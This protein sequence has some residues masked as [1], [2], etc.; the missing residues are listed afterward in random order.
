MH[1]LITDSCNLKCPYCFAGDLIANSA[2]KH[3]SLEDFTT[4][5]DFLEGSGHRFLSLAG[6]EPSL[7]PQASDFITL[8]AQRG[9]H[10]IFLITNGL[11]QPGFSAFL[12]RNIQQVRFLWNLNSRDQYQDHHWALLNGNLGTLVLEGNSI[13]G[14]NIFQVDQDFNSFLDLCREYRPARVRCGFAHQPASG[15]AVRTI[16]PDSLSAITH[17]IA[18]LIQ[19]LAEELRIP[20][21]LDCGFVPCVW[22]ERDLGRILLFTDKRVGCTLPLA[23]DPD[24][25]V[26]CCWDFK[27]EHLGNFGTVQDIRRFFST[28]RE[29]ERAALP[30]LYHRCDGCTMRSVGTCDGGC[31][32]DRARLTSE[33]RSVG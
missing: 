26:R 17:A 20:T 32:G 31:L 9:F 29:Q 25:Y 10:P 3:M 18:D 21:Q 30:P 22:S 11:F 28:A 2:A 15:P 1:A 14:L 5:L 33:S 4:I 27:K 19:I 13:F 7:H 23:V 6:G 12:H 16:D 8:G 24:L